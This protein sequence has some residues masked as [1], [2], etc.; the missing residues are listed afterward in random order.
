[1]LFT[2]LLTVVKSPSIKQCQLIINIGV[3]FSLTPTSVSGF[4]HCLLFGSMLKFVGSSRP[5]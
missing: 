2:Q 5:K 3:F 1:M 4:L